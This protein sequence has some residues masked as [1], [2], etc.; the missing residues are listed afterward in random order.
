MNGQDGSYVQGPSPVPIGTFVFPCNGG[1]ESGSLAGWS[2]SGNPSVVSRPGYPTYQGDYAL[3]LTRGVSVRSNV[4]SFAVGDQISAWVLL[5][6]YDSHSSVYFQM[7]LLRADG[8]GINVSSLGGF[9][10]TQWKQ[11]TYTVTEQDVYQSGGI[12]QVVFYCGTPSSSYPG[13]IFV[14]GIQV[15]GQDGSYVQGPFLFRLV[16]LCFLVMVVL[17]LGVLLVGR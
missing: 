10:T 1:F 2:L 17:S 9:S 8:T 12:L 14:D 16:L 5:S 15:N 11:F 6:T 7:T 13:H 3:S 4:S